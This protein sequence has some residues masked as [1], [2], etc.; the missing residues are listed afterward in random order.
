MITICSASSG[1]F[2]LKGSPFL[3]RFSSIF[4]A[5]SSISTRLLARFFGS[6]GGKGRGVRGSM[7]KTELS[8]SVIRSNGADLSTSFGLGFGLEGAWPW[9]WPRVEVQNKPA[10]NMDSAARRAGSPVLRVGF[11]CLSSPPGRGAGGEG[12]GVTDG[13]GIWFLG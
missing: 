12:H 6:I 4:R 13:P 7:S 3:G 11:V 8:I 2:L 1:S 10:T 5:F 9:P